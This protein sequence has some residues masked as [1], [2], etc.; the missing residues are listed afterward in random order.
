MG[1]KQHILK[2]N[3]SIYSLIND[4][5]HGAIRKNNGYTDE[6]LEKACQTVISFITSKVP[7]QIE[8]IKAILQ[9]ANGGK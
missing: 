4:H 3:S 1:I 6:T 9:D 2:G 7:G 8:E 5:S